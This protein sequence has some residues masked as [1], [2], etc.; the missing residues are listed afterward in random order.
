MNPQMLQVLKAELQ[1]SL[2]HL[3]EELQTTMQNIC[4]NLLMY[5]LSPLTFSKR[6]GLAMVQPWVCFF[7]GF[8]VVGFFLNE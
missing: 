7:M 8:V 1:A 5:F 6:K 3:K 2:H 4:L